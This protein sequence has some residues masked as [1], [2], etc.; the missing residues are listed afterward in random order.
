MG[1]TVLA[2]SYHACILY[3]IIYGHYMRT[4]YIYTCKQLN[5]K[6]HEQYTHTQKTL[7]LYRHNYVECKC[8][9]VNTWMQY[10]V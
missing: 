9:H 4:V 2:H 3:C 5:E 1:Y 7:L 6:M 8:V 10:I